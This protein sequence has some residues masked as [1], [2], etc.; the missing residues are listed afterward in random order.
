MNKIEKLLR[1][2][3]KGDREKL[4]K[5]II[6]ILKGDPNIKVISIKNTDFFRVRYK[7]FRIIFHKENGEVVI[8]SIKLR[9]E[10]TYKNL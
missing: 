2:I 7:R 4:L 9:N 5:L 10:N 3:S 8:D 6:L 1:K